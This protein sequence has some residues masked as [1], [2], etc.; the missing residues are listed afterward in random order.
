MSNIA[1][2][3]SQFVVSK[4][5]QKYAIKLIRAVSYVKSFI[6]YGDAT[7]FQQVFLEIN[8]GCNRP[9]WYCPEKF[10]RYSGDK[11]SRDVLQKC[12]DRLSEINYRGTVGFTIFNEALQDSRLENIIRDLKIS[13]PRCIPILFT[14]G[15]YLTPERAE[16]LV[17]AGLVRCT[18]TR[19]P[20]S[21]EAWDKKIDSIIK[22]Y[23]HV[24]RLNV[25]SNPIN[26]GGFISGIEFDP[27][28]PC[29]SPTYA[30]PIRFNGDVSPC[31]CDYYRTVILGNI[32]SESLLEIWKKPD[33]IEKR[34]Q[35]SKGIR[36]W[37]ICQKCSGVR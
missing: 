14:N 12:F 29:F 11:M 24:F 1:S 33:F 22:K 9:C 20:P 7:V 34:K 37:L 36:P 26:V 17:Q 6:Q 16:S 21:N 10:K 30:L 3:A 25:V 28:V 8:T 32:M 31:C 35:L 19:H 5:P 2:K 4:L 15:D 23:P 13:V 18:I 27:A